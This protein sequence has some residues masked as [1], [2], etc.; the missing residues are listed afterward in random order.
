MRYNILIL[1]IIIIML[2]LCLALVGCAGG[3][4]SLGMGVTGG[5]DAHLYGSEPTSTIR[6]QQ[7][8][9]ESIALE[10]DHHSS[11]LDGVP[12]KGYDK[13]TSDT[14]SLIYQYKFK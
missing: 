4:L 2:V 11:I 14:F 13:H 12:F 10:Y 1:L 8:L 9:T 7:T 6:Y 5:A 3:I